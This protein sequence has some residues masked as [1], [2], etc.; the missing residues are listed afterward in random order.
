MDITVNDRVIEVRDDKGKLNSFIEDY[1]P[2]VASTVQKKIGRFVAY[3]KDEE[4]QIALIAFYEAINSYDIQKGN[5]IPYASM[6]INN[7]LIDFFRVQKVPDLPLVYCDQESEEE[8]ICDTYE[9]IRKYEDNELAQYRRMEI[10]QLKS[11]LEG[12]GISLFKVSNSSPKQEGTKKIYKEII[13]YIMQEECIVLEMK[14]KKQLPIQKI[15][16]ATALHR[17]KVE[18]ARDYIIACVVVLSGEYQFLQE[19]INWG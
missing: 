5:F 15:C 7:R 1:K 16:D 17:K 8:I 6:V 4:L 9:S 19:F 13:N 18:R 12:Y 3:G 2:F 14:T 10:L 11:E